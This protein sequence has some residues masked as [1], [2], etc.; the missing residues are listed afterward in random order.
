MHVPT[1]HAPAC[2]GGPT[3]TERRQHPPDHLPTQLVLPVSAAF[4]VAHEVCGQAPV[5][6][7]LMQGRRRPL[8]LVPITFQ[9]FMR[10]EAMALAGFGVLLSGSCAGGQRVLLQPVVLARHGEK[11]TMSP[12]E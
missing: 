10:L 7:G 2:R 3:A 11:D 12:Q 4:D 6:Q 5:L 9:A 8:R 1:P